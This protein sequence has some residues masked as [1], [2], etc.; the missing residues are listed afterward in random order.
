MFQPKAI[1]IEQLWIKTET[2]KCTKNIDVEIIQHFLQWTII[3]M[4]QNQA[5]LV[6]LCI[7][8]RRPN[9][10]KRRVPTYAIKIPLWYN[11]FCDEQKDQKHVK[12]I[13]EIQNFV[14]MIESCI[15]HYD[16]VFAV[17]TSSFCHCD[18]VFNF[19]VRPD[20]RTKGNFKNPRYVVSL[21]IVI[22]HF[23]SLSCRNYYFATQNHNTKLLA[24]KSVIL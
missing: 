16:P 4:S 2:K 23:I 22:W 1:I 21:T 12:F 24:S 6:S 17:M 7:R 5:L 19:M 11:V 20:S 13:V 3:T 14:W 9:Y 18:T 15:K 10:T 8:D